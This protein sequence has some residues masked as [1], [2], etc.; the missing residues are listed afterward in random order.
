MRIVA[1][2][3]GPENSAIIGHDPEL[4]VIDFCKYLPNEEVRE[5]LQDHSLTKYLIIEK[6]TSYGMPVGESVFETCRWIGRFEE[7]FLDAW[8][9]GI[10]YLMPRR[11]VKLFWCNSAK[12]K[13]ANVYQA[14][15][16]RYEPGLRPR[17]KPKQ[18]PLKRLNPH[19]RAAF[20]MLIAWLETRKP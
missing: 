20:A 6:I 13:D 7:A 10:V 1:I 8:P 14:M 3:P 17:Q 19:M 15:K 11:E 12:A 2:D 16:D 18:E 4:K 5:A 9:K